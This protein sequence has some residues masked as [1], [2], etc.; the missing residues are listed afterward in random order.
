MDTVNLNPD[1]GQAAGSYEALWWEMVGR[2][3][4]LGALRSAAWVTAT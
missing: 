2:S 1:L 4:S 3:R